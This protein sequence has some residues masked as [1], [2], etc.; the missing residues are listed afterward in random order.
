MEQ[1]S[2]FL[3][4]GTALYASLKRDAA[5]FY[6]LG[7][8]VAV[9]GADIIESP[10][11]LGRRTTARHGRSFKDIADDLNLNFLGSWY[12]DLHRTGLSE[13]SFSCNP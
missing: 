11:I 3:K 13:A 4:A 6:S 9:Y 12:E 5:N 8:L 7:W 10:L 1:C 2:S